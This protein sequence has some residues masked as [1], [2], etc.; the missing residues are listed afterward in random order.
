M[1]FTNQSATACSCIG[2]STVESGY[3]SADIVTS[4]QVIS[5]ETEWLPDS[6]RIKEMVELG[7]PADS[8]DKRFNGY[9][10][11]KVLILVD[12]VYKG[13]NRSDTL[14]IYTGMGNGDCGYRF[15]EG[16][17][18]IIYA[19]TD[20]Y[21]GAFFR[22]QEFPDGQNVYWTNICKRTR[23][24]NPKEIKELEKIK[25]KNGR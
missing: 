18:Y 7:F 5:I 25:N 16:Q 13:S 1:G 4:G 14:A 17:K 11:R 6:T 19:D 22:D 9:Y 3:K 8:L 10:L 23:E 12:T 15:R 24:H 21:F 2:E 20:S